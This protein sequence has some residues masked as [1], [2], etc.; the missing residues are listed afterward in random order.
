MWSGTASQL[1]Q[2]RNIMSVSRR[3][4]GRWSST[5]A[6]GSYW[7]TLRPPCHELQE[8]VES[9]GQDADAAEELNTAT[10]FTTRVKECTYSS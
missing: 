7:L 2:T 9:P 3:V 8:A 6:V 10:Q 5:A 1:T 4:I